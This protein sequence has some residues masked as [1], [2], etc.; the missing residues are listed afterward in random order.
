VAIASSAHPAVIAAAVDALGL[1]GVFGAVTSADEV[2]HGK[3][4]PDVYRLAAQRLGV[5]PDRCLVVEDS[6]N[7]VLA[8]KAAGAFVVLVPNASVPPTPEAY[9]AA[10]VVI[11]RLADLDPDTLPA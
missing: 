8:G 1:D 7:G 5:A 6:T 2:A 4:E 10:D 11:G 9:A 3:P